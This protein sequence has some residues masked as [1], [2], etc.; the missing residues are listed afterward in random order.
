MAAQQRYATWAWRQDRNA[1]IPNKFLPALRPRKE[2]E[3]KKKT[4]AQR[5]KGLLK[6]CF[7][8]FRHL[9]LQIAVTK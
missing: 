2:E 3:E 8:T 4:Y 1:L 6:R 9:G 5:L 7:A